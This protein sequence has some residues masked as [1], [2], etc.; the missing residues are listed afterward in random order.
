MKIRSILLICLSLIFVLLLALGFKTY[1]DIQ[2][3]TT[4]LR[5]ILA[6]TQT[7]QVTDRNGYPLTISY[8][9]RWNSYDN[10]PLYQI[11]DF[12][13]IAFIAAE[14]Q[15]YYEHGGIDWRARIM[16]SWQNFRQQRRVR[17]ASTITEQVVRMINPRPRTLWAKWL[18]GVEAMQL[19]RNYSKADILE[20]YLNQLPY[21]ANRRGVLQAARYYFDRDLSTLTHKEILALAVLA[22]APSS[23]DLYR[24]V[25]KSSSTTPEKSLANA[26]AKT[27]LAINRL[28]E[29]LYQQQQLSATELAEIKQEPFNLQTPAPPVNASHFVNYVRQH[30]PAA[31]KPGESLRTTLDANVQNTVQNIV[32][33]RLKNLENLG[34]HNAAVLVVDHRSGQILAWVIGGANSGNSSRPVPGYKIDA[35]TAPRQP[36]SALKPFLYT[37]ALE[38]GWTPATIIDDS[39]YSEA[40]GN[41]MHRFKNY[42]SGYY[43]KVTL[44]E[45]LGNSLNIPALHTIRFVGAGK[46]LATLHALGF[47]S[48]NKSADIYNEGLAL[49]NG[50]V[51][52]LE[53]VQAY[54]TLANHGIFQPLHFLLDHDSSRRP[55]RIFSDEAASL[56]A[57]ILSDSAA[58]RLEFG[59]N[60]VLNLPVQTAAKTGTSTDYRDAWTVGFNYRYVV[61]VWMGNLDRN[62]MNGVT[63]V[64]GPALVMRSIFAD[65]NQNQ[66]T[67]ALYLSPKLIAENICIKTNSESGC[68]PSTEYFINGTQ[69]SPSAGSKTPESSSI[70]FTLPTP[71]LQIAI[72]PRIPQAQQK[73]KFQLN[74]VA[75]GSEVAWVLNG[76]ILGK[77]HSDY[78]LWPL[79]KG[80]HQLSAAINNQGQI[81]ELSPISFLVK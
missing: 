1:H 68:L 23:Y 42:S 7:V 49:G 21:A 10:L 22:R 80:K 74:G 71:G 15:Y 66:Q 16:A 4:S 48:L 55:Q 25:R 14:D 65:L 58:R 33:D 61:G 63:G 72:D 31:A 34:V 79:Q 17:G 43:G 36:G 56:I 29:F 38:A 59:E 62:P 50:E 64:I 32:D 40:I 12:L 39:P 8:Q 18:E 77:T 70:K 11:P 24:H 75:A 67:A 53:L 52:L 60:S 6:D 78:Y 28:A 27:N 69:P 13:K 76:K 47:T 19:E 35:V 54:A 57:N 73:L 5:S 46:Y 37:L 3:V 9:N 26:T 2:P 41:G 51:S 20:F 44:R 81:K 45:A 30:F